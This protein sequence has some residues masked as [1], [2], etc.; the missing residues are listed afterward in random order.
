MPP[1]IIKFRI[2]GVKKFNKCRGIY[3][4]KYIMLLLKTNQFLNI[5]FFQN[6]GLK[7]HTSS[8]Q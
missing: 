6:K 5:M 2:W 1:A 8:S 4:S 7:G 3:L